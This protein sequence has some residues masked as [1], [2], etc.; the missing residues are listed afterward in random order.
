[1]TETTLTILAHSLMPLQ[2]Q[3]NANLTA[4]FLINRL[5]TKVLKNLVSYKKY[6]TKILI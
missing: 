3:W 2:D 5:P 6:F 1:M 4:T